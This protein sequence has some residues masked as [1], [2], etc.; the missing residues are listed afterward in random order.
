MSATPMDPGSPSGAGGGRRVRVATPEGAMTIY[1][2]PRHK[3]RLLAALEEADEL[4]VDL[5]R[6]TDMDTAGIQ[7][8]VLAKREAARRGKSLRLTAHSAAS[9]H[10]MDRYALGGYFGDPVL[11]SPA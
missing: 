8:L 9:L 3:E 4:E 1:E 7:L 5:S 6:V 2:A 10:V 11:I